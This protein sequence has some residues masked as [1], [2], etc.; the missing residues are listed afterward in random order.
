MNGHM[1]KK[2]ILTEQRS[3]ITKILLETVLV[4]SASTKAVENKETSSS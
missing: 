1:K 3:A 4:H 2:G